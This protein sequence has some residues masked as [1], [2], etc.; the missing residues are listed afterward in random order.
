M[1]LLLMF[2]IDQSRWQTFA[3]GAAG[4]F[5]EKVVRVALHS[6]VD[7][8]A[9]HLHAAVEEP[10]FETVRTLAHLQSKVARLAS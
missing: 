6:L 5:G 2:I 10:A 1:H 3:G 9:A 4:L 8:R 7:V